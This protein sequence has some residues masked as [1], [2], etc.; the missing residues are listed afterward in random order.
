MNAQ[1][2]RKSTGNFTI[3]AASGGRGPIIIISRLLSRGVSFKDKQDSY[4][5]AY[6]EPVSFSRLAPRT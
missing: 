6:S 1:I 2:H 4:V 5:T 3:L